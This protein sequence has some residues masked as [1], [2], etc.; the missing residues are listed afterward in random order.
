MLEQ[1]VLEVQQGIWIDEQWIRNAGLG[2][3][4]RVV[5][6]PGEIRIL[7]VPAEAEQEDLSEKGWD[8][9][10]ALGRSAQPGR[11]PNAAAEHDRYLYGKG[12]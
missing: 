9:F 2:A 12:S 5:V 7:G 8:V 3:P 6:Q 1:K 10:R 4:L 11:L